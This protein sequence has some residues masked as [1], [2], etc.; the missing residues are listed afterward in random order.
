M[1]TSQSGEIEKTMVWTKTRHVFSVSP[2]F[3]C[4]KMT[5]EFRL[6]SFRGAVQAHLCGRCCFVAAGLGLNRNATK[7]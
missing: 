2:E 6:L 1:K 4:Q 3:F 5:D 7:P